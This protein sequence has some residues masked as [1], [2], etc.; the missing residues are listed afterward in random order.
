MD[1]AL[2]A[3]SDAVLAIAAERRVDPVLQKLVD[4]A[5][6]LVRARYAAIGIPDGAGGFATFI[7]SG[8]TDAQYEA[9]GEL[10]RTHGILGAMLESPEPYRAANVQDDPRFEGW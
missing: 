5:R 2:R 6:S 10:P 8:M 7:T 3:M 9:L 4:A 1:T